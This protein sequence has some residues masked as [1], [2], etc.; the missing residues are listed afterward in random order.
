[1]YLGLLTEDALY[2]F[3]HGG[4]ESLLVDAFNRHLEPIL[5]LVQDQFSNFNLERPEHLERYHS[6]LFGPREMLDRLPLNFKYGE[7]GHITL[8]EIPRLCQFADL[9]PGC[10]RN[11][12][13]LRSQKLFVTIPRD[14]NHPFYTLSEPRVYEFDG[15]SDTPVITLD[16]MGCGLRTEDAK[17]NVILRAFQTIDLLRARAEITKLPKTAPYV[18][19]FTRTLA[20]AL[21]RELDELWRSGPPAVYLGKETD[22]QF[23]NTAFE[24]LDELVKKYPEFELVLKY[25]Q[26]CPIVPN[27]MNIRRLF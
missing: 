25:Y 9:I 21:A 19:T 23:W 26:V 1:M 15:S 6:H 17:R 4:V 3:A 20:Y 24:R 14:A 12:K 7:S 18:R 10:Q 8:F 13:P 16:M 5:A 22:S 2:S 27:L 11:S